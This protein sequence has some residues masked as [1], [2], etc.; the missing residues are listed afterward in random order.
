MRIMNKKVKK[1]GSIILE[2]AITLPLFILVICA[3][4]SGITIVNSELY[5]QRAT[6]NV[7]SELNVAIPFASNGILCLDDITSSLGIGDENMTDTTEI[8][9]VLGLVGAACGVTG[10]DL[11]DILS[12][13]VLGRY[14]RDRILV[15]YQKL[16]DSGWVYD[17]LIHDVS[18]YLDYNGKEKSIYLTVFYDISC[19]KIVLS[20]SYCTSIAI[21]ADQLPLRA[22]GKTETQESDS[23]WDQE[24]FDRGIA[25]R[26]EFG[27]NLPY[28]YPVISR[29]DSGEAVSI[30]SVDTT[31]PYYMNS[32]NLTRKIKGYINDLSEFSGRDYAGTSIQEDEIKSRSLL[33]VV[34]ENGSENC[35]EEIEDLVIYAREQGVDLEIHK[36]GESHRYNEA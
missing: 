28:N 29:F 35:L 31:S 3:M 21:Y 11:E 19:G 27:G 6:E 5:L 20:R 1:M 33:L 23:V 9:E 24:N 8:D 10:V 15:E 12:T 17:Q 13:A 2:A 4:V 14:T 7:V 22:E 25:L 30:K 16:T 32:I 36:F 18:V 34:P 26:E